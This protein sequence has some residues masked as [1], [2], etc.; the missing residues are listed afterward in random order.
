MRIIV[1]KKPD[2]SVILTNPNP[3]MLNPDSELRKELRDLHNI[4]FD[5]ENIIE[6]I[7]KFEQR[8]LPVNYRLCMLEKETEEDAKLRLGI[9][10]LDDYLPYRITDISNI[11]SDRTFRK[12]WH[13]NDPT[14]TVDVDIE[15]AKEI[16]KDELRAIR[17][18]MLKILDREQM[19]A[20]GRGDTELVAK[21][22]AQKQA[23][24]DVTKLELPDDFEE[25]KTFKPSILN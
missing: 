7:A 1:F 12:A 2:G 16:R 21:I 6:E 15:K 9:D 20:F 24:R 3:E 4:D 10:N 18:P 5:Q 25:L 8:T 13:D 11:P 22:E 19:K 17:N 23:L 14:E